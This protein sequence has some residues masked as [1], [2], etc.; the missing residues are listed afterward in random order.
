MPVPRRFQFLLILT[1]TMCVVT[2]YAHSQAPGTIVTVAGD[3]FGEGGAGRY[4]GDAGLATLASFYRPHGVVGDKNGNFYISDRDNDRIRKIT[5]DGVITTITEEITSPF[6][7]CLD[8]LGNLYVASTGLKRV[9]QINTL[10]VVRIVAGGGNPIDGF[11]DGGPATEAKLNE[12]WDVAIDSSFVL[13]IADSAD[14]RIRKVTP[15]GIITTVAGIGPTGQ[16]QGG[17]SGD[18]GPATAARLSNPQGLFFDSQG[19]LYIVDS[20]NARIRRIDHQGIITTV[21]GGGTV[22]QGEGGQATDANLG[23]QPSDGCVDQD[24]NIY[25]TMF[26]GSHKLRKVDHQGILTTLAGTGPT[27]FSGDGGPAIQAAL[28][29]PTGVFVD[30]LGNVFIADRDN[31]RIRKIISAQAVKKEILFVSDR[32]DGDADIY[33]M[34]VDGSNVIRL[35]NSSPAVNDGPAWSPDG[36][37]IAFVSNRSDVPPYYGQYEI[38]VMDA[39]GSNV[40]RLTTDPGYDLNPAWS[41]DGSKIV[42][43]STRDDGDAD[44]YVMDADGSNVIRLT[45][46]LPAVNDGPVWSPD[47]SK[48]AFVSNRSDVPPYYGQYEIYVMDADGSNVIRLT[49]DPGYDLKPAWSP[50][51]SK[52]AFVSTRDDGDEDIYVMD[53]DGSNV[54]RLTNSSPTVNHSPVWAPDG[55]K[56]A[57]VSNRDVVPVNYLN[58]EIYVMDADGGNVT[59]L[60]TDD[61]F[62]YNP[63]WSSP[64]AS[65]LSVA[66][67]SL[68]HPFGE[69]GETVSVPISLS[70]PNTTS[71]GGLQWQVVRGSSAV[72]FDSLATSVPGFTASTNT[73]GDT[74]FVLFYSPSGAVIPPGT[75]TLGSLAYL[76]NT[77][78]PLCMRLSLTVQGLV[79]SDSLGVDLPDSAIDGEIQAGIP[80]DLNLDRQISILDIVQLVRIIVGKTPEP[81]STTC[82]FFIADYND[83]DGLDILDVIGQVNVILHITKQIAAPAPTTALIRLGAAQTGSSGSLVIP[84]EL[85]SDGLVAGLQA[86]VRFD[87]SVV[88]VGLPQLVGSAT[89]LSLDAAVHDGTLRFVVFGTQPGQGIV[90]GSGAVLL[91]PISLRNGAT[92][93]PSFELSNVVVASAQAQRVPVTI[94]APVKAAAVPMAFSLSVNRPNPFNPSTQIA[95]EVPQQAHLTLAVYNVLGQ[96]VARLVNAVQQAGRYTVT[97]DGR[98]AQGQAASSGVYLYRLASSTGYIQ[99]RRMVLLK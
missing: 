12:P 53:A 19:N 75:V 95:Y 28:H 77:D 35:T 26:I 5:P 98:N 55:D 83:D 50:D 39:D 60:T 85:Q 64:A 91:I 62:D 11:G 37:K 92:E 73:I 94:G 89:G 14:Q 4:A 71:I 84:V 59:R 16:G 22:E 44:I 41:P 20:S 30:N 78:A 58:H 17:F 82:P 54:I 68:G 63:A 46:S 52:I 87:P 21:V 65:Q 57:F 97:W 38:Y 31:H 33:V 88:S 66:T 2:D 27:G 69:P 43:V 45:N 42:F 24:G 90:A 86:T 48:I 32:D 40:I 72:Q 67:V 51:G 10:G 99:S 3:G 93:I 74:T 9:F 61:G 6:G 34:N 36:S 47:G 76:I 15:N 56:I 70:N 81:D 8:A 25:F 13:Y 29:S 80:G 1:I 79:I 96:E 7:M 49:T 18:G 23:G